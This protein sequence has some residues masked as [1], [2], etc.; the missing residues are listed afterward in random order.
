MF[1]V[2][3]SLTKPFSDIIQ[4]LRQIVKGHFNGRITVASNDEIGVHSGHALAANIGSPDRKSYLLI[5]NTV[6][7]ASRLQG[8]NKKFCTELIISEKTV[9]KIDDED[10]VNMPFKALPATKVKGISKPVGIYTFAKE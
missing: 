10:R 8:L 4:A 1:L 9:L 6:N 7:I 3:S 2:S 5:G